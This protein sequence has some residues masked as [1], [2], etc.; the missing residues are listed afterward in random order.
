MSQ[1]GNTLCIGLASGIGNAVFML[2]AVKAL[3]D[4]GHKI[5]L[6]VQGDYPMG[7]LF[8]RCIYADDVLEPPQA[9][10]GHRPMCGQWRPAAWQSIRD[11][12]HCRLSYPYTISEWASNLRLARTSIK[13]DVSDWCRGL[14]RTPRWDIGIAPGSKNGV[15]MRKRYPGMAAVAEHFRRAGKSVA[16]FGQAM[17]GTAEI[18]GIQIESALESLP[19]LLAGCRVVIGTDS[20]I[21]HLASSLG[22]PVVVIYTATSEIKGEPV[23]PHRKIVPDLKCHPCQT[24]PRWQQCH[25]WRCREINAADVF[26][27]AQELLMVN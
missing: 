22:I 6:Y 16:V 19:D 11:V 4:Q 17:D 26:Q 5:S 23:G 7:N 2:P 13:P 3:R 1:M 27:S 12:V 15:W 24:T 21:T 9:V 25:D 20:G 14:D 18:P 8:R 10:N